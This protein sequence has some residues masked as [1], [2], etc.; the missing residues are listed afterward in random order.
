MAQ[1]FSKSFY[2][3][4]RWK[5][6]RKSYISSVYGL[7]EECQRQGKIKPGLIL[8]HKITLTPDNINDPYIT[9]NFDN[10][11]YLC[12]ECHNIEHYSNGVLREGLMFDENGD[13][14][15]Q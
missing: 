10:L 12:Q 14:V 15:E 1:S 3:S 13:V 6:C 7:C 8:H 5:S 2:A 9:L 11:E 4:K